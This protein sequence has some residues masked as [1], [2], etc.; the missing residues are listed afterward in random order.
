MLLKGSKSPLSSGFSLVF[1]YLV[2]SLKSIKAIE[3]TVGDRF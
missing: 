3:I 2:H 1:C